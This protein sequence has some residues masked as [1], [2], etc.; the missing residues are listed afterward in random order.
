MLDSDGSAFGCNS[1]FQITLLE[2]E[3]TNLCWAARIAQK[4]L[5]HREGKGNARHG[6]GEFSW[7]KSN[8]GRGLHSGLRDSM[9][10]GAGNS[11]TLVM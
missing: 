5:L 2:R 8:W 11:A 7:L 3:T 1:K 9:L 10:P 4:E 6:L